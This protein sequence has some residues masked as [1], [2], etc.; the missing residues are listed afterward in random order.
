[1]SRHPCPLH[2]NKY[3]GSVVKV[4]GVSG[5]GIEVEEKYKVGMLEMGKGRDGDIHGVGKENGEGDER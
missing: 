5:V 1:M 4:K 2:S 3:E